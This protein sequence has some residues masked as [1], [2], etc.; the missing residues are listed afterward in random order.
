MRKEKFVY[1]KHTLRYEKVEESLS[2]KLLRIFGFVC[3]ALFS[4]FMFTL[5]AHRYFPSPSE[6]A[7]QREYAELENNLQE[8]ERQ[9][10]LLNKTLESLRERDAY[11]YR[12][13][14]GMDPI[15]EGVW[16]GGIG[17]SEKYVDLRNSTRS[18]ELVAKNFETIDNLKYKLALQS[19]SLDTILSKALENEE[20][21][22]SKPMI[23]PVSR[24]S[25]RKSVKNLS[26]WGMRMHPI[27]G[28]MRMHKGIDFTAPEGTPIVATGDGVV[29][30]VQK[31]QIGYGWNI[32]IDHGYGYQ[33]RYAHMSKFLVKRGDKVIR[34]QK[35][36]LIGN[37]GTS[38]APHCHYEVY[39]MGKRINP[40]NYVMDDLSPA[41]YNKLLRDAQV[42][43]QSFD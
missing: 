3:A 42:V 33:T 28:I 21:M 18:G 12:M 4:A 41:E 16:Q 9:S 32:I 30:L 37:T 43:N 39:F 25:L 35:I 22:A 13:V 7:L 5:L 31:K 40:I 27:H 38:T 6:R 17:G 29:K 19:K 14:F 20:R 2:T 26:G 10:D 8:F 34:G 11:A 24:K 15:D 1:N 36:G 23:T